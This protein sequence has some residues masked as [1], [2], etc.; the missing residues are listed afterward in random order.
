[1]AA[2]TSGRRGSSGDGDISRAYVI[3]SLSSR[4]LRENR[5]ISL[6]INYQYP[7]MGLINIELVYLC[8]E[9]GFLAGKSWE[10]QLMYLGIHFKSPGIGIL[11]SKLRCISLWEHAK[12]IYI[13]RIWDI[14]AGNN[15]RAVQQP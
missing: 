4:K 6:G 14:C 15:I 2:G 5:P 9:I 12:Y 3:K 7:G 11:H 10:M 13:N 8:K 1:M